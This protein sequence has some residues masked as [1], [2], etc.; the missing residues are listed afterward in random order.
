M[1]SALVRGGGWPHTSDLDSSSS[2]LLVT[3]TQK[4]VG[5][6][7]RFFPSSKCCRPSWQHLGLAIL[8]SFLN[9]WIRQDG[10]ESEEEVE[11]LHPW[12]KER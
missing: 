12:S 5:Q 2:F 9:Q 3:K 7:S 4:G 6:S 10:S 8:I 11:G 1:P